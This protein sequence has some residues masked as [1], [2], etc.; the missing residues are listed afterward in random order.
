M[1]YS[2]TQAS[3]IGAFVG[4]IILI[5]AQ[6]NIEI[7]TEELTTL[8]GASISVIAIISNWIHRYKKG[9]ITLGG[10]KK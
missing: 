9:D 1:S 8:I 5:L 6:F 7:G 4:V 2:T 3:N 10:V